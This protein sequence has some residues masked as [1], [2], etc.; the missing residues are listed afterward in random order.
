[1]TMQRSA[2][3]VLSTLALASCA[4]G[5]TGPGQAPPAVYEA[6]SP[7][8]G[9]FDPRDFAWSTATGGGSITGALAYHRGSERFSCQGSDVLLTP[10]TAWSRR[11]M[12]ILYGSANA[13]AAP[14]SIVRARTPSAGTGDYARFVRRTT[15]DAN[16]RFS[17]R[18]LPD[19][20]W[21]V[22][23]VG[24]PAAGAG[25]PMAVTRRVETHGGITSVTL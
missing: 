19:G 6:P 12:F 24:K 22:I 23:T 25:E 4:E 9:V 5:P 8:G 3:L 1:M 10:E 14:V 13:A 17:F 7:A 18:G 20:A 16:S 2:L 11:R 15:C 21:Y